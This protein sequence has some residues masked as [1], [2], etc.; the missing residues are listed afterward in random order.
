[1]IYD[2]IVVENLRFRPSTRKREANVCKNL[3]LAE[4]FRKKN[5]RFRGLFHR[6][7]VDGRPNWRENIS[8]YKQKRTRV[9]GA[10]I[11]VGGQS[12]ELK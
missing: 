5:M 2:I 11:S 9:D 6:I 4:R 12:E 10:F 8:V 3:H 1:M 7:R